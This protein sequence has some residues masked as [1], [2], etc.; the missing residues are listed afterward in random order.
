MATP[1]EQT[2]DPAPLSWHAVDAEEAL[3]RTASARDGLAADDAARRLA[4]EGPNRLPAA[5]RRAPW[6]RFLAQ[7]HN[8]LIHVL[9]VA[10]VVTFVLGHAADTAVI[11]GVVLANAIIGFV[12]EG[13]AEQALDAIRGMIDPMASVLRDGRRMTV[14]AHAIVR[15]DV[16]LVESGDRVPADLRLLR[17]RQLRVDEA[18]L[19]GESVPVEK[20]TSP[21]AAAAP[22]GDRSGMLYSGTFVAAGQG[23]GLVVETAARTELG[24]I[25]A[26]L[27]E[28]RT[29][30]TPLLAQMDGFARRLTLAILALAT[31][32]FLFATFVRAYPPG[33]AFMVVVGIAVAAIPE[34]LPAILTIALAIGVQRMARRNAIIRRLPAVE[35]LGAV[36]VICSDKTGT[37]TRNEMTAT[38]VLAGDGRWR[39]GGAGYAP[40]GDFEADG[41]VPE[42][43][44]DP[45]LAALLGAAV[46]CNDAD[47]R[48]DGTSWVVDGDPMEGALVV[49]GAKAGIDPARLRGQAPRNDEIP[50]DARHRFMAT[51][52]HTHEDGSLILLKGAPERILEMCSREAWAGGE[53]PLD[54]TAWQ[55]R[56]ESLAAAGRR[57]LAFA[58]KRARTGQQD[59]R[60]DDVDGDAC[61]LGCVGFIDPPRPEAVEAVAE[62]RAAGV[63]VVMITGDHAATAGA[64]ARELG[65]AS[66]PVVVAGRD[67]DAMDDAALRDATAR[68]QV[69][70]RTTPEHKLRLVE[71]L[72]AQGLAVA[73]TGDGVNDAPA[74]KRADVGVAMGRKGTEAAKEA[75]GMVLADDNFA[76]IVAAVRE[77]RTVYDNV[78][79]VIGWTLPTNG[80]EALTIVAAIAMGMALPITPLQILWVNMVTAVA[81]GLALAFE[82]TEP[83]AMRRPPR[84]RDQPLLTRDLVWRI[85][86]VSMLF[87]AGCFG[88][89]WWAESRGLPLETARTLV[90]NTLVAMEVFYLFS[91]RYVHGSA[92]TWRG[93]LGT[94]A[95]LW[96][97]AAIIVLQAAFTWLPPLQQVFDT[98][99]ITAGEVLA[100]V[101]IGIAV[102]LVAEAEKRLRAAFEHRWAS[103]RRGPR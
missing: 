19:T 1:S 78:L 46:L 79:K 7:F 59:L 20:G 36:S 47:L 25:S 57:V 30:K 73:M 96:G 72:Q 53:R 68:A 26:L 41:R 31:G 101:A 84:P 18:I 43:L 89:F 65:L 48:L 16:V 90:V 60:F 12:Q 9:L 85:G 6:L 3:R 80:G 52:H 44:A 97:V 32:V 23:A 27:G 14:P 40:E 63:R 88:M 34:G 10:A 82:P 58:R 5:P 76:S 37:L 61:L 28:V 87:V 94:P 22:L 2:H 15:G 99:G 69:F 33:E 49:L 75:A 83:G 70:A 92:L 74:L 86:F 66:A 21:V 95:V 39:V 98:R 62:C 42:P 91:V 13:K 64:I 17:A 100:V 50:F 24:R 77:G 11:L 4:A 35:T 45:A 54:G 51:L 55:S 71:A 93:V 29:L 56:A 67:L 8:L 38:D 102:L 103:G 81:L